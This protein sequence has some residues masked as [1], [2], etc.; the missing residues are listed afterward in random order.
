MAAIPAPPVPVVGREFGEPSW[1]K[2]IKTTTH[3]ANQVMLQELISD[4]ANGDG[5]ADW[6][7]AE[8]SEVET[9][10][11]LLQ[12]SAGGAGPNEGLAGMADDMGDGSETVTRR[13]E[14]YKYGADP[15]T[16]DGETGEAMCSEVQLTT[17]PGDPLF[18]HG[19]GTAVAVTDANGDTYYVNC[20]AQVVVGPYIGAQ[21]AGFAAAVPLGLVDHLQD[22]ESGVPYTPRTV[23]VGG[24]PPYS[25]SITSES[26]PPG[27]TIGDYVQDLEV[28]HGVMTGTPTAGGDF[29]F[30]VAVVDSN[31][32]YAS[33]G[34]SLHVAGLPA[35]QV[36]LTVERQGS[37]SGTVSG[38]GIACPGT[39]TAHIDAGTAISLSAT[40]AAGSTFSG[41]SGPCSGTGT[42]D[43][44]LTSASTVVATFTQQWL[45]TVA[46]AGTGSGTVSDANIGIDCGQACAATLDQGTA[47][48]LAAVAASG[49]VFTGWSGDCAGTGTCSPA[50]TAARSVTATFVPSTQLFPITVTVSG[51]GSVSSM[52]KGINCGKQC[53][54]TFTVGT[55]VTLTAKPA[56]KNGTFV[57]WGG[58]CSGTSLTCTLTVL[59]A[60]AV[61]A[62]F[63]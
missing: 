55:T 1:V 14:F 13:Y 49:S 35:P 38:N 54:K 63:R 2:V 20:E 21:M 34:Y 22:G 47:V 17:D 41:W 61:T 58:A 5:L 51:N 48:A 28:R 31:G 9:E 57:G 15:N 40:P 32:S 16:L 50:M 25:I 56:R 52:P 36:D 39:C 12:A 26:L 37:G 24:V 59:K 8:P 4:D 3:N 18:L 10:W 7:N 62:A 53:S 46:R 29:P 30:T 43:F 42:C 44:A 27:L 19:V 60:E 23:V 6:Q 45:L 33:Q 11:K